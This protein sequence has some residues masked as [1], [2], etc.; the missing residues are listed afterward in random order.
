MI[1]AGL[2]LNASRVRAVSGPP[3]QPCALALGDEAAELPMAISLQGRTPEIGRAGLSLCRQSPHLL[4]YEFLDKL[5]SDK[6]WKAGRHRLDAGRAVSLVCERL[7][8]PLTGV[9]A[10]ALALPSYL[11]RTQ[12]DAVVKAVEK[13]RLLPLGSVTA[14]LAL[15]LDAYANQPWSQ[16][17][18]VVDAD[19]AAL[20]WTVVIAGDGQMRLL[21]EQTLPRLGLR[22]WKECVLD[23]VADRCVRHSR[24]DPRESGPA[25]QMLYD[26]IDAALLTARSG[27]MVEFH[28]QTSQWYQNLHVRPEEM[29]GYGAGLVRQAVEGMWAALVA[30]SA[31]GRPSH[32][33]VSAAA[34]PL[35]G[36]LAALPDHLGERPLLRVL[37]PEAAARSAHALAALV[38]AGTLRRG[39]FDTAVPLPPTT[40]KS[41]SREP[42]ERVIPIRD[43]GY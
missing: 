28:I 32:I 31:V 10:L 41:G 20:T 15:A 34:E 17:A 36:L 21:G 35:P 26:Q 6:D 18:L 27:Q 24:R 19:D 42:G 40:P 39:Q 37:P 8:K 11:D 33:L 38:Q 23:A 3:G 2:D 5:G 16:V 13:T 9:N 12:V 1:L 25:E 43:A 30:V 22:A 4:C 14:P 7:R 29:E